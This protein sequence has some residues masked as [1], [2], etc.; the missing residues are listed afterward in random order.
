MNNSLAS[1]NWHGYISYFKMSI[2][3]YI[4]PR[5]L[6]FKFLVSLL[7]LSITI[8]NAFLSTFSD[9]LVT[10]RCHYNIIAG[11]DKTKSKIQLARR[12][13]YYFSIDCVFDQ[14][15]VHLFTCLHFKWFY[16]IYSWWATQKALTTHILPEDRS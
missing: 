3:S 14:I 9:C 15:E 1:T 4:C 6:L 8:L 12:I 2:N 10:T 13:E 16:F 11:I 5:L 7:I